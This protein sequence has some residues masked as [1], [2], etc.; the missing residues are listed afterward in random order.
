MVR[1]LPLLQQAAVRR[2]RGAAPAPNVG[3][4]V[5]FHG[6]PEHRHRPHQAGPFWARYRVGFCQHFFFSIR[7]ACSPW[8]RGAMVDPAEDP[9]PLQLRQRCL[10]RGGAVYAELPT[11]TR[12]RP[13]VR[14][15]ID[16]HARPFAAGRAAMAM[17]AIA[18]RDLHPGR[19]PGFDVSSLRWG[20]VGGGRPRIPR[21][22]GTGDSAS[23]QRKGEDREFVKLRPGP[24]AGVDR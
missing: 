13:C 17:G 9:D 1:E 24:S 22:T 7:P 19:R 20:R 21:F 10:H 16:V 5:E 18:L 14:G 15:G 6:L 2:G 12:S 3:S 23:S 8:Q 11:N 4:A